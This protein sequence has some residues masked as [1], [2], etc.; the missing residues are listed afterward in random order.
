M[1]RS[2]FFL[3]LLFA[4]L[5]VEPAFA[6]PVFT[7][8][9]TPATYSSSVSNFPVD[10]TATITNTGIT[11]IDS[12]ESESVSF[13]LPDVT[14]FA[15]CPLPNIN[16]SNPLNPGQSITYDFFNF[17]FA[18]LPPGMYTLFLGANVELDDVTGA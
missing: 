10:V 9:F 12:L 7:F 16:T 6:T 17:T 5:A 3:F 8:T 2:F 1:V 13:S 4:G 14:A 11:V 15:F 18:G